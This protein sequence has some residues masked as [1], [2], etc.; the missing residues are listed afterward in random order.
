MSFFREDRPEQKRFYSSKK[1]KACRAA[2]LSE[3]PLCERCQLVGIASVAE[4][5]HHKI[6]LTADTVHNP[7]LAL[8]PDNLEALCFNC[9]QKEHHGRVEIDPS[10]YF[11]VNGNVKQLD[12]SRTQT[13]GA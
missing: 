8:N 13:G 5:V 4:H 11:D 6:E 7:M 2:Y 10:L 3:H 1:W 9:H 12:V